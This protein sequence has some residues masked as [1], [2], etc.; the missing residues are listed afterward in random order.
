MC[1]EKQL[2]QFDFEIIFVVVALRLDFILDLIKTAKQV[3]GGLL[4]VGGRIFQVSLGGLQVEGVS[5][6]LQ[7]LERNGVVEWHAD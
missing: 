5:V 6:I 1:G 3:D 7:E 4:I 2:L